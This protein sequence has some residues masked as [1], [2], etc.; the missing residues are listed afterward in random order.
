[1]LSRIEIADIINQIKIQDG[2]ELKLL[3]D[4]IFYIMQDGVQVGR[5]YLQIQ[6]DDIDNVTGQNNY[7][8]HCRKWYL[9]EHMTKQ[10]VVRTAW[11]AFEAAILHEAQEKFLY[12][13]RM[14]YGP[15]MDVDI[16]WEVAPKVEHRA[17]EQ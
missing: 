11:K 17:G 10:E 1:M 7:R 6:F 9:S 8:A 4:H 16:L 12:R 3:E 2:W 5:L 14:I 13:G 15:H